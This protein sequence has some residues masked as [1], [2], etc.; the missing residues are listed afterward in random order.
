MHNL[1]FYFCSMEAIS[2]LTWQL[3]FSFERPARNL[4]AQLI[5]VVIITGSDMDDGVLHLI[6][7]HR[8]PN[9]PIVQIVGQNVSIEI[10]GCENEPVRQGVGN[11]LRAR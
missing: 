1:A 8:H 6:K 2:C 11:D 10:F 4:G 5:K 3:L 9:N 7:L